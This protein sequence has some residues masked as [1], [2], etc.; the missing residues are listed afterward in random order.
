[1]NNLDK[2]L[3]EYHKYLLHRK[4]AR[5]EHVPYLTGWV[6]ELLQFARDKTDHKFEA[7]DSPRKNAK[8][9]IERR[10]HGLFM[11]F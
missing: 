1:M 7:V 8:E 2:I 11:S 6:R 3:D 10:D 9:L 5:V 4:L